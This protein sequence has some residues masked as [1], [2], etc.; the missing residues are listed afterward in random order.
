MTCVTVIVPLLDGPLDG[1]ISGPVEVPSVTT[2]AGL[3]VGVLFVPLEGAVLAPPEG[4]DVAP[5]GRV[6]G[7]LGG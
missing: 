5:A 4:V 6:E 7:E 3:V 1:E 2:T